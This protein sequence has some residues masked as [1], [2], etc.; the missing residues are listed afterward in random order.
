MASGDTHFISESCGVQHI[1]ESSISGRIV[2]GSEAAPGAWPWQAML[3][4]YYQDLDEFGFV[5]GG[6]LIKSQWVLT[7][8]HC[9]NRDTPTTF[10]QVVL[11]AHHKDYS[12]SSAKIFA[13]DFFYRHESYIGSLTTYANDICLIKLPSEI[14]YSSTILPA[15]LPTSQTYTLADKDSCIISG[16]GETRGTGSDAILREATVEIIPQNLCETWYDDAGLSIPDGH[17]CAGYEAGGIDA[18]KGDSGGPLVCRSSKD[19]PFVL[20]GITSFGDN[21]ALA[22]RPGVYTNATQFIDWIEQVTTNNGNIN[23]ED[24]CFST[25]SIKNCGSTVTKNGTILRSPVVDTSTW[26]YP[27]DSYCIWNILAD[28]GWEIEIEF[29]CFFHLQYFALYDF[30][31]D[32]VEIKSVNTGYS[33]RFCGSTMPEPIHIEN[34]EASVRFLSD[35]RL[36][37]SGFVLQITFVP[38]HQMTTITET[39]SEKSTAKTTSTVSTQNVDTSK[40][41][42]R[43]TFMPETT[44][45]AEFQHHFTSKVA[46]MPHTTQAKTTHAL[47]TAD[48]SSSTSTEP[49]F[50]STAHTTQIARRFT[51]R[52][53]EIGHTSLGTTTT[54]STDTTSIGITHLTS[55]KVVN[56]RSTTTADFELVSSARTSQI[57]RHVTS[58][59]AEIRHTSL[60][61]TTHPSLTTTTTIVTDTTVPGSTHLTSTQVV[62]ARATIISSSTSRTT[63][64]DDSTEHTPRTTAFRTTTSPVDTVEDTTVVTET[65]GSSVET[66]PLGK[67]S[68]LPTSN[69]ITSHGGNTQVFEDTTRTKNMAEVST[70]VGSTVETISLEETSF[71]PTSYEI[72]S[73]G[74]STPSHEDT[75]RNK[76]TTT[77]SGGS[78]FTESIPITSTYSATTT[79]RI[80]T[81]SPSANTSPETPTD[82]LTIKPETTPTKYKTTAIVTSSESSTT[83]PTELADPIT[84]TAM[85]ERSPTARIATSKI[86]TREPETTHISETPLPNRTTQL[87]HLSTSAP[88][89]ENNSTSSKAE[90]SLR[91]TAVSHCE[92]VIIL[93]F[94][95]VFI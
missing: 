10:I 28:V 84:S 19:Q 4:E 41:T 1:T 39:T 85:F 80:T 81:T 52:A 7:A 31:R 63:A 15:C 30:C 22:Q 68:R 3:V 23:R 40:P 27:P 57:A 76:D 50:V 95:V 70:T 64:L 86:I 14:E 35:A 93:F 32:Y 88:S 11:G 60:G 58:Q 72:T 49:G 90:S 47:L 69:E 17:F 18:C 59:V 78:T 73:H 77:I 83:Q 54:E 24:V 33:K 21:C 25:T 65:V 36:E 34:N 71:L 5:C 82:K 6:T 12:D 51:S 56:A 87:V 55:T 67:T 53:T 74:G 42:T 2:G 13:I 43:S 62:N 92:L 8:A 79:T 61:E 26:L 89:V 91:R 44:S 16:W 38:G 66:F 29:I 94:V 48:K 46:G 75:T 37:L 20:R 45:T 9:I